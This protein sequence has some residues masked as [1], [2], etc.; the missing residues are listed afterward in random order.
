MVTIRRDRYW[1]RHPAAGAG[2]YHDWLIDRGSLTGRIRARCKAFRVE[3]VFQGP[4]RATREE[5][6]LFGAA[7]RQT[8]VREVYLC[9]GGIPVVFAHSV[10]RR[11]DLRR[12][13]RALIRLGTQPLG[14]ALFANPRVR[15][16]PLRFRE[17][18]ARDELNAR[19]LAGARGPRP[20]LWARRSLFTLRNSPILVTEIFLP[21]ILTL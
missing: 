20:A 13:W 10:A 19:A 17:L 21:G 18:S 2:R 16:Q 1:R 12:A 3:L 9:C 14:A 8:L 15:R 5:R 4:R 11:S 6:F 7:A